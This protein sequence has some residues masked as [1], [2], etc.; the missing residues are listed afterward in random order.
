VIIP[1]PYKGKA[2]LVNK[3][4]LDVAEQL[5]KKGFRV[6]VDVRESIT[7]GSKYFD[8]E[9]KGVPLRVE[10]GPR[11]MER[12]EATVVRRDTLEK[13]TC[14]RSELAEYLRS[15]AEK[16]T[17]DMQRNAWQWTKLH[18]NQAPTLEEVK[19]LLE[20][21]VGI[22]EV[23]WCGKAE[24]GHKLEEIFNARVLGTPED[25]KATIKGK[26]VVCGQKAQSTVRT[27]IAY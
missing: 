12:K 27:A 19:R 13:Q 5:K 14:K 23:P 21:R 26:C 24:C 3:E 17:E 10:I 2:E 15:L 20:K 18:V 7:P 25:T 4:C 22:V 11:D 8:W 6:E 16:M 1:I 9:L